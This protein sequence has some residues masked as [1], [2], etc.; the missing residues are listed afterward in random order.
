MRLRSFIKRETEKII[1]MLKIHNG[2]HSYKYCASVN[3][4]HDVNNVL[5]KMKRYDEHSAQRIVQKLK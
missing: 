1:S 2:L 3:I 5:K 4:H